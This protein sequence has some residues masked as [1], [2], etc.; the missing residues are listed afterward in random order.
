VLPLDGHVHTEWSWD[1]VAGSM[2]H[3]CARADELGLTSIAFTEHADFTRWMIEPEVRARLR[4]VNADWVGADG[5]FNPPPLDVAAYLECVQRCRAR[6]PGLRI[7]TG[8][9][10]GE[11]HWHGDEV[12][13]MLGR[14]S[15]DRLLGSVHSLALDGPW[16]VDHLFGRLDPGDLMP[17]YLG[18]ALR[19]IESSAPFEVLAHID[20]PVRHWPAYA[21]RFDAA[22]FEDEYRAVLRALARSGRMLE[23]NTVVP[24]PAVIIRWWYEAGGEALTFGS[25]AHEPSAV[26][27]DFARAAAMAEAA[28]FRPGRHRHDAWRRR[29]FRRGAPPSEGSRPQAAGFAEPVTGPNDGTRPRY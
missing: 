9:E 5:R 20:Y 28:G 1:A 17:G 13:S 16:M 22:A 27:R 2:G 3:S 19:L 4:R 7:L 6:F 24:L 8:M 18:E 11:P 21:G 29:S 10:L 25:D 26:A 12:R 23:V 14:G 15:F